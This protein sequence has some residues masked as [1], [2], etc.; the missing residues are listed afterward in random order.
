MISF[1]FISIA[2]VCMVSKESENDTIILTCC[3]QAIS[4]RAY[5]QIILDNKLCFCPNCKKPLT[6]MDEAD[7]LMEIGKSSDTA[8]N[9][10]RKLPEKYAKEATTILNREYE[11]NKAGFL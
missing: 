6:E 7:R 11:I 1:K 2:R 8:K 3:N 5:Y 9:L 4:L 10:F